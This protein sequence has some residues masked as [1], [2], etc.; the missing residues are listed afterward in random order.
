MAFNA[1]TISIPAGH[2]IDI[3]VPVFPKQA[4]GAFPKKAEEKI[5]IN[6]GEPKNHVYGFVSEDDLVGTITKLPD[7][8]LKVR[9]T[10]LQSKGNRIHFF[11]ATNEHHIIS[12]ISIPI[13]THGSIDQGGPAYGTYMA[14]LPKPTPSGG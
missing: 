12:I 14:D 5:S 7:P 4:Q 1:S 11:T 8:V 13:H 2:Y 10:H 9:Y 3:S 6:G